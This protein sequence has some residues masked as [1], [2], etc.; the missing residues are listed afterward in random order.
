MMNTKKLSIR[1]LCQMSIFIAIIAACAQIVIPMPFGVPIT[2][3]T[4]AIP[5]AGVVLGAKN[6]TLATVVY[7]LLGAIGAP[8]FHAFTGGLNMVFGI[9]G[10]F[11]LSFP[12][13]ALAAGI[14]SN[15]NNR[16]WLAL[17]LVIGAT[18]NY[19][20]GLLWFSFVT[21][22]SLAVSVIFVVLP[23][24]PGDIIKIIMV[25]MLGNLIKHALV[26]SRVLV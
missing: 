26:K 18:V 12:L 15:K 5:L 1:E 20:C 24:I 11:I 22:N 10:G 4:F 19:I 14:G 6:G 16:L 2:L 13:M 3:Q 17:W 21:S 9:T 7:V 23:F 25:V 8:V